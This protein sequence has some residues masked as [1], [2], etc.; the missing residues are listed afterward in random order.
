MEIILVK[1][2]HI[3]ELIHGFQGE[4]AAA[5]IRSDGVP[6]KVMVWELDLA[7]LD[8]VRNFVSKFKE[9]EL[10]L[11]ILINN[12]GVRHHAHRLT[13]DGL[14]MHYQ[15]PCDCLD[16]FTTDVGPRMV[17]SWAQHWHALGLRLDGSTRVL[18][19]EE[20]VNHAGHFLLTLGLLDRSGASRA[21]G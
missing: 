10:P 4:K 6:G 16:R 8:S 11:H 17:Q 12:G 13:K 15:V 5:D 18:K 2:I 7:S 3:Q 21:E 14:E 1:G 20:Q 19:P 9:T